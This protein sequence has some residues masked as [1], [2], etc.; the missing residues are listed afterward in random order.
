MSNTIPLDTNAPDDPGDSMGDV[1]FTH[2][3]LRLEVD[4]FGYR[5]WQ[6]A[7]YEPGRKPPVWGVFNI[8]T[9]SRRVAQ[10]RCAELWEGF[11][12]WHRNQPDDE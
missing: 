5:A 11:K 9:S 2:D 4:S 6:C 10:E 7:L 1:R 12:A 8:R 3:G